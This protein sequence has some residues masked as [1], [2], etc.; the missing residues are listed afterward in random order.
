M[1][2]KF[3]AVVVL[4]LI[5][6]M[7]GL[8]FAHMKFTRQESNINDLI[9]AVQ[10]LQR[11]AD[12]ATPPEVRNIVQKEGYDDSQ[13]VRRMSDQYD[14]LH[15]EIETLAKKMAAQEKPAAS[16]PSTPTTAP[17]TTEVERIVAEVLKKRDQEEAIER[18]KRT[19]EMRGPEGVAFLST[20]IP[21]LTD[22]QK[23]VIA[24]FMA[25][26]AV[27][28]QRIWWRPGTD[29]NGKPLSGEE[30]IKRSDEIR[31]EIY[32]GI[33]KVLTPQQSSQ[34]DNWINERKAK[35]ERGE[36]TEGQGPFQWF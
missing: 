15:Q 10:T 30:K 36:K 32:T 2:K 24:P 21:D 27:R 33:K 5:V 7:V 20:A 22:S 19:R 11:K 34:F 12:A 25:D 14:K 4:V 17:V 1:G 13:L 8:V 16:G 35:I 26:Y 31:A 29:E 6:N 23:E 18:E 28:T 9:G 3:A